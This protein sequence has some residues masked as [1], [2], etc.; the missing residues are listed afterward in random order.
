LLE[1]LAEQKRILE[2]F[3][4]GTSKN[5]EALAQQEEILSNR[6]DEFMSDYNKWLPGFLKEHGF[7]L[8]QSN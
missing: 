2:G 4:K 7:E 3:E 1:L 8:G 5:W 6:H